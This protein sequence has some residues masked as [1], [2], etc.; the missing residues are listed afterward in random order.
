LVSGARQ[1]TEW[2]NPLLS[3]SPHQESPISSPTARTLAD[4]VLEIRN[5]KLTEKMDMAKQHNTAVIGYGMSAKVF[6]IPLI[7]VVPEFKLYAVVQRNPK[8]D[9]D[10]EKDHPGIKSFRSTEEMVKDPAIEVVVVTTTP[11]TH[12]ELTKIALERGKHGITSFP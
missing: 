6:H 10:A 1:P 9:D 5:L 11:Q 7:T 4:I 3:Y 2:N 8:A 12:F